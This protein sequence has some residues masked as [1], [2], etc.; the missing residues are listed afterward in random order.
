MNMPFADWNRP[1]F[2]LS[3]LA[4]LI[5][6]EYAD[7]VSAEVHYLNVDFTGY[8]GVRAYEEISGDM[9]HLYSGVGEWLFRH[10][11]FP[12]EPDN[13]EAYFAR[14]YREPAWQEFRADLARQREGVEAFLA[15]LIDRYDL[16]SADVVGLTT[17][18]AQSVPAIAL[19]KMIKD[20]NPRA[21][22]LLGGSNVE[23]S[24]GAVLA[25][26]VPSLDY[27]FSGPSLVSFA[28][29]L[30]CVLEGRIADISAIRGVISRDNCTQPQ[31]RFGVGKD[32]DIN[33][34][35]PLDYRGFAAAMRDA[36]DV[37]AEGRLEPTL[38]FET[39]R[40]CWW[41]ARSH[42]TFCGLNDETIG[43]RQLEPDLA[44]RQFEWLFS[45]HP[46]FKHFMCTD[47]I[48][49]R[50]YP[51]E[52]FPR[53]DAPDDASVFY[54][55]KL[56]LSET[57]MQTLARARVNRVQAGIEAVNSEVLK[58]L[59]K[60]T[61]AFQ[62]LQFMKLC[63]R[64]G[65]HPEWN[66]LIGAPK[67]PEEMYAKYERDFPLLAHLTPPTGAF[68]IRFDRFSPY[69][70]QRLDYGLDLRPMDFYSLVFPFAPQQL[71]Q[72]A[73]F[74]ADHGAAPYAATALKWYPSLQ[75]VVTDWQQ[76]WEESAQ[77]PSLELLR[78]DDGYVIRDTRFGE[79]RRI[80]VGDQLLGL[81]RELNSPRRPD[82]LTVPDGA[83]PAELDGLVETL[84]Q[85]RVLFEEDGRML[86]L[87]TGVDA[88]V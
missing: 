21:V 3:Q 65:I 16:A 22:V 86:S 59:G 20:R 48:L 33:D 15:E 54:E 26:E 31:V 37:V 80:P 13:S 39:S 11:A 47:Y 71:D 14:Y 7:R 23:T 60:G 69:F 74:F 40:G 87:V 5:G 19:A 83:A 75:R 8:F 18:F 44:V 85:H 50:N 64:Y 17:M 1:S 72:L 9:T 51:A 34:Y 24:M 30:D 6:Q 29:F 35:V 81:L 77:R 27:V 12:D 4:G 68:F 43:F 73:Y 53:V 57:H 88:V 56:P 70:N 55:I 78:E 66:L 45:F 42:C 62:S 61:T 46:E 67:E 79:P 25:A 58:L 28:A 76:S 52:V 10:I 82:Q 38:F 49:P 2:A 41:G 36:A 63:L 84:R 32:R